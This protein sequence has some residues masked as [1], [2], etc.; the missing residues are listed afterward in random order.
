MF[1]RIRVVATAVAVAMLGAL[2]ISAAPASASVSQG[3][4][5]GAGTW[6]DDWADEG[7]VSASTRP[8]NNVV[9]MWQMILWADGYLDRSG[10]DCRFGPVTTAATTKWQSDRGLRS[11]GVVGSG[12]LTKAA[13]RLSVYE[14]WFYYDGAGTNFI[15]FGRRADGRWDMSL[16]PDL[17]WQLLSY[18]YANFSI[19]S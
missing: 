10:I 12:T 15:Y 5:A 11:D 3:Y 8:H 1:L 17:E 14:S 9:A 2:A 18:T 7:P 6:T 16:G 4:V 13:T 19:C